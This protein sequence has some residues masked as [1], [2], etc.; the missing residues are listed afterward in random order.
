MKPWALALTLLLP[1]L[2][3]TA[4]QEA[5]EPLAKCTIEGSVVKATTGE[6]VKRAV[7]TLSQVG[8]WAQP[9]TTLQNRR[10]GAVLGRSGSVITLGGPQGSPQPRSTGTDVQGR[11][12]LEAVEPGQYQ[13]WVSRNGY[14]GQ[15][16]GQRAPNRPGKPLKLEPGQHLRDLIFRLV[17]TSV[18]TGHVFGEDGDSVMGAMVQVLRY[19]IVNGRRQ[20][21]PFGGNNTNDVGEYRIS[22]L[23]PGRYYLWATYTP[24]QMGNFAQGGYAPVYYPGTNR[25]G[26]AAPLELRSGDEMR[27][28]DFTLLPTPT[29]RLRGQVFNSIT[30]K[31]GQGVYVSLTWR[32]PGAGLSFQCG[33]APARDAEGNFEIRSVP[34][35]SY[36]LMAYWNDKNQ[37]YFGRELLEVG[38][39]DVDGIN[40]VI[41]PGLDLK[42]RV[43]V[44]GKA[45]MELSNMRIWL[46]PTEM[47]MGTQPAS[48]ESDGTFVV[49]NVAD[50][51]YQINLWG[52][53]Q[54]FYLKSARLGGDGA[55]D[56]DLTISRNRTSGQLELV[57]SP[58]GGRI[59]GAVL[60]NQQPFSGATVVLI[61]E[62][63]R[64]SDARL[65]KATNTDDNGHF[66]L[67]GIAPGEYKLFAWEDVENG[68]YQDPD[69][70]RSYE[71]RGKS[72]RVEEGARLSNQL[73]LIPAP[74]RSP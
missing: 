63:N 15:S 45:P 66:S 42:G 44:E 4:Q 41:G 40:L 53:P 8:G 27:D 70:L 30:G 68:A 13:I 46:Q 65:Y 32:E 28:I 2:P 74:E 1:V 57:L 21:N 37:Q 29:V 38:T 3:L 69:F 72:V 23:V 18:I 5:A 47:M 59:D 50:G 73:E 56:A 71:E 6:P 52:A 17:P 48:V 26:E 36:I 22:G 24:Q 54:D 35:G 62:A 58:A 7:V 34:P 39:S 61:P 49:K 33:G 43:S 55:L 10:F 64:R 11:F 19:S 60:N 51:V 9:A 14:V 25:M 67:Q 12:A 16:Y 20:L 31:P